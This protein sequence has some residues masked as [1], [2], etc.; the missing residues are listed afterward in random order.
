M[1]PCPGLLSRCSG[2]RL[3]DLGIDD[4]LASFLES[5]ARSAAAS[6]ATPWLHLLSRIVPYYP[7]GPFL[8]RPSRVSEACGFI[9]CPGVAAGA[10]DVDVPRTSAGIHR[11]LDLHPTSGP[12]GCPSP[13]LPVSAVSWSVSEYCLASHY[14]ARRLFEVLL[15]REDGSIETIHSGCFFEL[16]EMLIPATFWR[17]EAVAGVVV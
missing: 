4:S 2:P 11:R 16:Q 7:C 8:S 10:S 3:R 9:E 14:W 13:G 1:P 12:K 17:V 15:P 6:R 5:I